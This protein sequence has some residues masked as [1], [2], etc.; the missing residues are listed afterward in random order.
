MNTKAVSSLLGVSQSTVKRWVK[1]LDFEMDRNEHGHYIFTNENI[2]QLKEIQSKTNS[3]VLQETTKKKMPRRAAIQVDC[4]VNDNSQV[5]VNYL[6]SKVES[7]EKQLEQKAD[8]VAS[9]QLLQHRREIEDLQNQVQL[10]TKRLETL[11]QKQNEMSQQTSMD[12][13]LIIERPKHLTKK[14]RK[15]KMFTKIFGF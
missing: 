9:Y 10:L 5:N 13:Q 8:S 4:Q 11:E 1:Q 14:T 2:E 3:T 12:Q 7:L 15:I 6:I